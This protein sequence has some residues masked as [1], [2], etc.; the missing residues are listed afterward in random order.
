[1]TSPARRAL[2]V[3]ALALAA[4]TT[5]PT[6]PQRPLDEI[7]YDGRFAVVA[8]SGDKSDS[9]SGHFTLRTSSDTLILDLATP[10]GTTLAR[11]ERDGRGA[12]L[13]APRDD[14]SM[15]TF[16]GSD[17]E[18][19]MQSVFGWSIPVDGLPGWIAGRPAP[20]EPSV[21]TTDPSGAVISIEQS[22]WTIDIEE[23]FSPAGAPRRLRAT[24]PAA[25]AVPALTLRLVLDEPGRAAQ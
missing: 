5:V 19:L 3:A 23:R 22:G 4:C 17:P 9:G 10:L 21:V 8:R 18:Q 13:T 15:A 1:M 12:R 16:E 11:L 7:E 20:G 24:R 25:G 14:G 6:A 2:A